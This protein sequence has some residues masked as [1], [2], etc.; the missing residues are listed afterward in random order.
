MINVILKENKG[1][2]ITIEFKWYIASTSIFDI[3]VYKLGHKQELCLV[4][5]F[6]INKCTK[7]DLY[8]AILSFDLTIYFQV[9]SSWEFLL[10]TKKIIY[11]RPE[12]WGE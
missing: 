7:I 9:K 5:L 8:Q 1:I 6:S 2:L 10:N 3:V 4:I 12:F 11:Q